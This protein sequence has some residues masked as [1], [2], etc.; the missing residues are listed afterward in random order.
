MKRSIV[1]RLIRSADGRIKPIGASCDSAGELAA[2]DTLP[3]LIRRPHSASV[4][5]DEPE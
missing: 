3:K 4:P 1:R 5:W 2:P